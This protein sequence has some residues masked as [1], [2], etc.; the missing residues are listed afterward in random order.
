MSHLGY[1]VI[2]VLEERVDA[3]FIRRAIRLENQVVLDVGCHELAQEWFLEV[4]FL[5]RTIVLLPN[6]DS[7]DMPPVELEERLLLMECQLAFVNEDGFP[8][9]FQLLG[10]IPHFFFFFLLH[11]LLWLGQGPWEMPQ[12]ECSKTFVQ[13]TIE[14]LIILGFIEMKQIQLAR[15]GFIAIV[16]LLQIEKENEDVES[17]LN[18]QC[19]LIG[20]I[21]KCAVSV[22][23]NRMLVLFRADFIECDV[24]LL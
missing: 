18:K 22:I 13:K 1:V 2:E 24:R 15:R 9:P 23:T 17:R 11:L 6:L 7:P 20:S 5:Q 8:N 10:V 16:D 4:H 21:V 12:H 19:I 3:V 14:L